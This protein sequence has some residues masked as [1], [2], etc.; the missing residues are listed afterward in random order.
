MK[1]MFF[2]EVQALKY[3]LQVY[4]KASQAGTGITIYTCKNADYTNKQ[5]IC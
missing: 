1:V 4:G 5:V 3:F 2:L